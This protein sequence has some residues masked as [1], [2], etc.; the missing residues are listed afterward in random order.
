[1]EVGVVTY[2]DFDFCIKWGLKK[3]L[4]QNIDLFE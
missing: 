3:E 4:D 1:M 2:F